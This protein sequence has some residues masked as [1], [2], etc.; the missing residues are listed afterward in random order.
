MNACIAE[1]VVVDVGS[2]DVKYQRH[3]NLLWNVRASSYHSR[4]SHLFAVHVATTG[5]E[6]ARYRTLSEAEAFA[7]LLSTKEVFLEVCGLNRTEGRR[8]SSPVSRTAGVCR[9]LARSSN[10]KPRRSGAGGGKSAIHTRRAPQRLCVAPRS[11]PGF[12]ISAGD[13]AR[14]RGEAGAA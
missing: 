13:A 6:V 2:V 8:W 3:A 14:A 11:R 4:M 5:C 10:K 7:L 9:E 12:P 1:A